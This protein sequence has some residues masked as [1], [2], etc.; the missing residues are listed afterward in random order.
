MARGLLQQTTGFLSSI[1]LERSSI[2]NNKTRI[3]PGFIIDLFVNCLWAH[4]HSKPNQVRYDAA[5]EAVS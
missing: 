5:A 1:M 4:Q 2:V 3:N